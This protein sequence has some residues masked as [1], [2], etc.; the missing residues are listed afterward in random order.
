MGADEILKN[1]RAT[2]AVEGAGEHGKSW[3]R[4]VAG[5]SGSEEDDDIEMI[6]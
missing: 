5:S 3:V 4:S 1:Y 6:R 2:V